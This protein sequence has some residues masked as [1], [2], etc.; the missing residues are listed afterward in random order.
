[1]TGH[2]ESDNKIDGKKITMAG[3]A[4]HG[5]TLATTA[6]ALFIDATESTRKATESAQ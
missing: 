1:V 2:I 4:H 3:E 6:T 5:D